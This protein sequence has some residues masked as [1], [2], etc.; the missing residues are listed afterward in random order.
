MCRRPLSMVGHESCMYEC[1]VHILRLIVTS[2]YKAVKQC[3]GS[4]VIIYNVDML[5]LH[6]RAVRTP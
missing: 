6:T 4:I 2:K 3:V 5:R 1:E